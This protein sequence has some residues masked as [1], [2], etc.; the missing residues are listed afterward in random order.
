ME[1]SAKGGTKIEE[2][3]TRLSKLPVQPTRARKEKDEEPVQAEEEEWCHRVLKVGDG[4]SMVTKW[5]P[6]GLCRV[7]RMY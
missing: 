3:A 6:G 1:E 4:V 5:F 2:A 7:E